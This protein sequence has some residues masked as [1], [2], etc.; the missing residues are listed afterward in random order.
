MKIISLIIL[1]L[2]TCIN[3]KAGFTDESHN[4]GLYHCDSTN[5]T[6]WHTE[7]PDDYSSS[8]APG[9]PLLEYLSDQPLLVLR[10]GKNYCF[11]FD[12]KDDGL[13]IP[14]VSGYIGW[15]AG[16]KTFYVDLSVN[17]KT[18]PP[19]SNNKAMLINA[20]SWQIILKNSGSNKGEIQLVAFNTKNQPTRLTSPVTLKSNTWYDI[21]AQL[22]N[23]VLSLIVGGLET[24]T[25]LKG[26]LNQKT[27]SIEIGKGTN[28]QFYFNG[29]LDEIQHGFFPE[30]F[31]INKIDNSK[32][33]PEIVPDDK[34]KLE[35]TYP[36]WLK[37][38]IM[39]QF[40]V[41]TAVYNGNFQKIVKVLDHYAEMGVNGIWV[42]PIYKRTG[43]NDY[44]SF[45][46]HLIDEKLAG[47][48]N[49]KEAFR[50][51]KKFV[52]E[53]HKRNIRVFFD[54]VIWG[55]ATNSPLINEQPDFFTGY[56][57]GG[58]GRLFNCKLPKW[59]E[60][61]INQA[62]NLIFSTGADGLRCDMEPSLTEYKLWDKVR[63]ICYAN[64]K[65][66]AI[67]SEQHCIRNGVYDFEQKGV[68]YINIGDW[69][70]FY[71]SGNFY[72]S[73]NIVDSVKSGRGIGIPELQQGR[74]RFYTYNIS[75][76]SRSPICFGNII[77]FGY[78]AVLSPFIPMWYIGEEWNAFL[79]ESG[80]LHF[81]PINWAKMLKEPNVR[82]YEKV[83][84]L[85]RI[86]RLF[87]DIFNYY[88]I[89]HRDSNICK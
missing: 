23:G 49:Q 53:A 17:W 63:K 28:S 18:L 72:I 11:Y 39:V 37:T 19:F 82:F 16:E 60:W 20:G 78:Q 35:G 51:T 66:V 36:D 79:I 54:I 64:G 67:I 87:P 7:T 52:D 13:Y 34:V 3:I 75:N 22:S 46:P 84:K 58:E 81:A 43:N 68:G 77:K 38:L 29:W 73:N 89:N 5:V 12:G 24:K 45:G 40:R 10:S 8:R 25:E 83:K 65:K 86:R 56:G 55:V 32:L 14:N 42:D 15:P 21:N 70:K 71:E 59:Q 50:A 9:N 30:K 88:P 33:I 57:L 41:E 76:D 61:F 48:K 27:S 80:I 31:S 62:T 4:Y 1:L 85:I 74:N 2:V 44:I 47:A 69:F 6:Q 26:M